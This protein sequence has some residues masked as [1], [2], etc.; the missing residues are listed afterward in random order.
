[1]NLQT[2]QPLAFILE[3]LPFAPRVA[4]ARNVSVEQVL[5]LVRANTD[6]ASLGFLGEP[7]VNVLKLIFA[8]DK[9]Q[10]K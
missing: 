8:L 2:F 4:K 3:P 1:V 7:G 9:L 5:A 10:G 6:P